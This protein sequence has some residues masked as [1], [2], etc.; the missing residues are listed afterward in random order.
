MAEKKVAEF[1]SQ[2]SRKATVF[3]TVSSVRLRVL[4]SVRGKLGA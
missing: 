1:L 2:P 4:K 3:F